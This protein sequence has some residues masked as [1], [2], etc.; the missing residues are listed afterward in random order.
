MPIPGPLRAGDRG[1]ETGDVL[2]YPTF[3]SLKCTL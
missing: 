2:F 3:N 1:R